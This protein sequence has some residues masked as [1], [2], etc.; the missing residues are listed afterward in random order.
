MSGIERYVRELE[1]SLPR[2]LVLRR[3]ILVEVEDHL[4]EAASA[5]G[6]AGALASF[7]PARELAR[8]Y[9]PL[10]ARRLAA[11][12]VFA[13]L[14]YPVLSY[15]I[16]ENTL[17][18]A[19]WPGDRPP[20]YLHWKQDKVAQLFLLALAPCGVALLRFRRADRIFLAA[21]FVAVGVLGAAAVLSVVLAAQW[22]DAVP[23]TPSWLLVL[24]LGL[25]GLVVVAAALL[26][27]ALLLTRAG[28]V[29]S[30]A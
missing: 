15:P 26:A 19:P 7:G 23:G 5:R 3:R 17:P 28:R 2:G 25:L 21:L 16:A 18:P 24:P 11:L 29:A 12:A 13:L 14:A 8:R 10:A 27:R 9:A 30:N 20:D 4:R 1:R 6:E 22:A